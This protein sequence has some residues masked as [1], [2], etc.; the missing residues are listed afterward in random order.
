M[1]IS[2]DQLKELRALTQAPLGDCKQALVE[3]EW[4]I[5]K[6][7]KILRDKG[8]IK[9]G[10]KADRETNEGIVVIKH[11][12]NKIAGVKF[13]CETDFVAK[14]ETFRGMAQQVLDIVAATADEVTS[15]EVVSD[16][17]KQQIDT[18]IKDN[19]VTM[20]EN[21]QVL[22][23]FVT[24]RQGYIYTHPGDK[25]AVVVFYEG[26]ESLAKDAA[27]QVAAM[28]PE[29]HRVEDIPADKVAQMKQEMLAD[30]ANDTKPAD[31]KEKIV[32]WRVAKYFG[33]IVFMEQPSIKDETKK[34]K[35]L[36]WDKC[37]VSGYIRYAIG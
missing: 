19:F 26:D 25:I 8:A 29:Y 24:W 37:R 22:D 20:G 2:M 16:A 27:L 11:I 31:I 5:E 18:M 33:E 1:T 32:E 6:A 36:L 3:A 21:M 30:L 28:S 15:W 17:A 7:Q 12:W 9:A 13:A 34:M 4:D 23:V 14:N 35:D 10:K